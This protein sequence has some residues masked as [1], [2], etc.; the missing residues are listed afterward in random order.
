METTGLRRRHPAFAAGLAALAM[1]LGLTAA[2]AGAA[3]PVPDVDLVAVG[4]SYTAGIGAGPYTTPP[5]CVQ[6]STGYVDLLK[7]LPII[8]DEVSNE[9]CGGARLADRPSDTV[10]SVMEQIAALAASERLSGRTELVTLTA[11]ANDLDFATPLRV[12]AVSTLEVCAQALQA[13]QAMFPSIQADLVE[14][15]IAIHKAAP[16][17]KIVVFGYPLLFD[18]ESGLPTLLTPDAQRLVNAATLALNATIAQAVAIANTEA[19]ANAVY[20]DVT[21]DFAG[22][23]INSADPWINFDP[24]DPFAPQNFHPTLAGHE[25]YA[26]AL[27]AAVNLQALARR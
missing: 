27:T 26:D 21:D 16:R 8:D 20:V 17:A 7:A 10:P 22:H 19:K 2:P 9:A 13:A 5:P 4:D 15:L 6:T 23:A 18:P 3:P 11:G 14:A 12:C 24:L 25:A 1:A